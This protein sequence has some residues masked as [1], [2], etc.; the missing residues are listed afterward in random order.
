MA[1][2]RSRRLARTVVRSCRAWLPTLPR[3]WRRA[4]RVPIAV[5]AV[6]GQPE[7]LTLCL[8]YEPGRRRADGPAV[9]ER[10]DAGPPVDGDFEGAVA[11]ALRWAEGQPDFP[12]RGRITWA[13]RTADGSPATTPIKGASAGGAFAV[14][15]AFLF[16]L[17]P[18]AR[19][20]PRDP[21]AV[22]SAEVDAFGLLGPVAE[23]GQKAALVAGSDH[24]RLLVA[25]ADHERALAAQSGGR[26]EAVAVTS[27]AEA[28]GAG[29]LRRRLV[30]PVA[31]VVLVA[32]TVT[33]AWAAGHAAD[34]AAARTQARVESLSGQARAYH[35]AAPDRSAAAALQAH[36]LDP[37][38]STATAAMLSAAYGD[39]RLSGVIDAARQVKAV[40]YSPDGRLLAVSSG[41]TVTVYGSEGRS[42]RARVGTRAGVVT[43]LRFTA[44]GRAL[45]LGTDQGEVLYGRLGRGDGISLRTLRGAGPPVLALATGDGDRVAWATADGV[46]AVG[47]AGARSPLR[48]RQAD[49]LV[50]SLAF[51]PDARLA[52]GRLTRGDDPA[53]QVYPADRAGATPRTLLTAKK[54][55]RL[56]RKDITAMAVTDNGRS[57]V[58]GGSRIDLQV[59]D[60]RTLRLKKSVELSGYVYA[61]AASTDGHTVLVATRDWPPFRAP[62]D[63]NSAGSTVTSLDLTG[64]G[65]PSGLAYSKATESLTA[66]LAVHPR[67]GA[68][69][70]AST[71]FSGRS[72]VF[73]YAPPVRAG[74]QNQVGAVVGDPESPDS[75]LVLN[76]DGRLIRY[77]PHDGHR[78][79]LLKAASQ[80]VLA[81]AVDARSGTVALGDAD[82]RV[83][84]YDYPAMRP[85]GEPLRR[86]DSPVF[87]LA[88]SPDGRT[89]AAGDSS[90]EVYLW[91]LARR[92]AKVAREPRPT[93]DAGP[94]GTLAWRPD[95]TRL[96]VGHRL[97]RAEVLDPRTARPVASRDFAAAGTDDGL[98]D[99]GAAVPYEDDYLAGF[100]DGRIA[101]YGPTIRLR[102]QLPQRHEA[103]VLGIAMAPDGSALLTV[104]ADHTA[105]LQQVP[106]GTELFRATS[107][108]D[109]EHDDTPYGGAWTAGGFTPD[110]AWAVL[111]S[112]T[113]RL[114]AL[115]LDSEGLVRRLCALTDARTRADALSE[116]CR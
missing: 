29:L 96:L 100:G 24:A 8:R 30:V 83:R 40:Q 65:R 35:G 20:R 68:P 82:G 113:G 49:I 9:L 70:V 57:L 27:V 79:V 38:S 71:P 39:L 37:R 116:A 62:L 86:A 88:F 26:P 13:V 76:V 61:V 72:R 28:V 23:I 78:T 32:A 44:D 104:S 77:R 5:A 52:V 80:T 25:G 64:D 110:G 47:E 16:G 87:R 60:T 4:V 41:R 48:I 99:L 105:L 21:R 54:A 84:L 66:I 85:R 17:T 53:L 50:T 69:A 55:M 91:N 95:G 109:A 42:V 115:A 2:S 114:T 107:P 67:T 90:G 11:T 63:L 45:V 7:L 75:V 43:D 81:L 14:A 33:G 10:L 73:L 22:L 56:L 19:S 3:H 108:E 102:D 58:V 97:G 112:T 106:G 89:L 101:R 51:L 1:S 31:F 103:N 34:R 12:S 94:V 98:G 18:L 74:S 59:Y 36:V 15:L 46:E 111:G 93:Q 92:T 6:N